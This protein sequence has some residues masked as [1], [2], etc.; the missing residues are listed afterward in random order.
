MSPNCT[1][2]HHKPGRAGCAGCVR[3]LGNEFRLTAWLIYFATSLPLLAFDV[4]ADYSFADGADRTGVVASA[5]EG[6]QSR[7]EERE[8]L[9]QRVRR[10]ALQPVDDFG[11]TDRRATLNEQMYVIGHDLHDVDRQPQLFG[12]LP[13]QR[14]QSNVNRLDQHGAAVLGTP[15][16]VVLETED[17][18][19]IFGVSLAHLCEY[20]PDGQLIQGPAVPN[21]ERQSA[22][23]ESL[24][25]CRLKA[26][27]P[28]A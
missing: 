5:P 15:H 12:L 20:T 8:L 18:A 21:Q 19:R 13:E 2:T 23:A 10:E 28:E 4:L 3:I 1:Y 27:V 26:T 17:R 11:N 24:F 22:I 9:A 16:Y 7:L 25:R 6:R 14:L